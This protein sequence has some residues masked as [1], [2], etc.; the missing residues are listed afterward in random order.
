[1]LTSAVTD[2]IRLQHTPQ[3]AARLPTITY[4]TALIMPAVQFLYTT[5]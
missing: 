4:F 5:V 2:L 3:T 1:M